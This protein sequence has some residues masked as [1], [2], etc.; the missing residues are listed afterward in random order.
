MFEHLRGEWHGTCAFRMMPEDELKKATSSAIVTDEDLSKAVVIRYD[1]THPTDGDQA[2]TML[3]GGRGDD[4][5]R[6]IAWHDSWHQQPQV[7][8]LKGV[9]RPGSGLK[10][11][12]EYGGNWGWTIEVYEEKRTLY[13]QMCNVI[14]DGV[15]GA[16]PGPY[17]VMDAVWH[18]V[19]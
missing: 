13:M 3:V 16:K 18:R 17:V 8:L 15:E 9:S 10:V 1:W 5:E 6:T 11:E 12:M 2:G 14:P 4:D 7:A 19:G